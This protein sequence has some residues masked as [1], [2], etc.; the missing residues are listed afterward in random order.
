MAKTNVGS[1]R[2]V[3]N[4]KAKCTT[5]GLEK[6]DLIKN[7]RGRIVSRKKYFTAKKE[8]RLLK[9]GYTTKK[10]KFGFVKTKPKTSRAK[11]GAKSRAKRG[12]KSRAKR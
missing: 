1:R 6:R 3:F 11:R 9:Y 8:K 5:G 4:G 2:A 10:G 7:R 12:A